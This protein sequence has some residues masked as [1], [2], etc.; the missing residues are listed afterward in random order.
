MSRESY[1]PLCPRSPASAS[2]SLA[3]SLVN[4]MDLFCHTSLPHSLLYP[5][6]YLQ[7][8]FPG[9]HE[10]LEPWKQGGKLHIFTYYYSSPS[11]PIHSLTPSSIEI[12]QLSPLS[13][14]ISRRSWSGSTPIFLPS[15]PVFPG[16]NYSR[17]SLYTYQLSLIQKQG[18][19]KSHGLALNLYF[20]CTLY[21]ISKSHP[22]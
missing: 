8:A 22:W 20:L 11:N 19:S 12:H 3:P 14:P 17:L 13:A 1:C 16:P 9:A 5:S 4:H 6:P 7:H 21:W 18:A 10:P 15:H 2:L